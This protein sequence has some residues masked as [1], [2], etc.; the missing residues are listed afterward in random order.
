MPMGRPKSPLVL[1][2]EENAQLRA[3]ATSRSLPHGL[4]I[5]ATI[6]LRSA[7]GMSH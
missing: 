1:A 7:S 3:V 2:P 4:V 5:R 6:I